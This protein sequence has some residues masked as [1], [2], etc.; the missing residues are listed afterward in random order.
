MATASREE[1]DSIARFSRILAGDISDAQEIEEVKKDYHPGN[2][3][4]TLNLLNDLFSS[5]IPAPSSNKINEEFVYDHPDVGKEFVITEEGDMNLVDQFNISAEEIERN[6]R[7]FFGDEY[8]E[9]NPMVE[10]IHT[11]KY[12]EPIVEYVPEVSTDQIPA[13]LSPKHDF[14]EDTVDNNVTISNEGLWEIVEYKEGNNS[15]YDVKKGSTIIATDIALY[16][17]A[18]II[19][20]LLNKNSSVFNSKIRE[21]IELEEMYNRCVQDSAIFKIRAKQRYADNDTFRAAIAEDRSTDA[22]DQAKRLKQEIINIKDSLGL[23][24]KS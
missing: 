10:N 17:T 20:H 12:K 13:I 9:Q 23:D 18:I 21:V 11:E 14:K 4:D 16:E 3:D 8:V 2:M 19:Q 7:E 22:F 24:S 1:I 6:T 5:G 15:L